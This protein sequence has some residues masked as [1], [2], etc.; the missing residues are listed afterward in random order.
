MGR[1]F[2]GVDGGGTKTHCA[3]FDENGE[4]K[5]IMS[6]GPTNH[7]ALQGGM[8]ELRNELEAMIS[9]LLKSCN[10]EMQD[11]GGSVLGLAGVDTKKQHREITEILHGLGLNQFILC[12]DAYLGVK[13]GSR[14]G[15]G[16][17][18]INGTGCTVAGIDPNGNMLQIGGL[19]AL[20]DD[21]GGGGYLGR[22]V[23]S[24]VYNSLFKGGEATCMTSLL[25]EQLGITSKFEYIETLTEM[26]EQGKYRMKEFNQV[27]FKAAA[28]GDA[29][30]LK[31]LERMGVEN[32]RSI[33]SAIS[34][35]DFEGVK[36]L[37]VVLAGSIYVRGE[38]P[39]AIEKIRQDVESANPQI[40]VNFKVLNVAPVM[41]AVLWALEHKVKD[42][43]VWER[44]AA[45]FTAQR[46]AL[47]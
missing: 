26:L 40:Q 36:S 1:F 45:S 21:V 29:Q 37:D 44:V 22:T 5:C 47:R 19:G 11:L 7:E 33:N 4:K 16:I 31:I 14:Q 17:C 41:G 20:T 15:Y 38:H 42:A 23:V 43:L 27:L 39:A 28:T 10:V 9:T 46:E 8:R 13:A 6:W 3:L 12:N 35:L 25:F 18:A 24:T 34:M 30:A 32:A 2:I